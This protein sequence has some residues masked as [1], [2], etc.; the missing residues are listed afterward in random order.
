[1]RAL[2][3]QSRRGASETIH[4]TL[5][6]FALAAAFLLRFE[7]A[8]DAEYRGMLL[9][10]LPLALGVKLAVFRA[11][12]LRDLAWRYID[13]E[14]LTRLAGANATASLLTAAVLRMALGSAFPRSIYVLDLLLS[15]AL[16]TALRAVAKKLLDR[17]HNGKACPVLRR[18]LI[19]GAGKAG[20]M[21]L[22]E[23]RAHP[24]LG[25]CVAGFLDDAPGKRD[26]RLNGVRVLGDRTVLPA[27]VCRERIGEVLLALPATSGV[28]IGAIVEQCRAAH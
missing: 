25:Y 12:A 15:L 21:L 20:R 5:A 10:A 22:A 27:A 9:R 6:A 7:F 23:I 8:I 19:Y 28:E 14:D 16:M 11:F 17:R 26:L 1:M 2:L 3:L 24:E 18:I 4:L 13:F